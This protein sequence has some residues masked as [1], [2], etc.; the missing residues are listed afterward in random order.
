[1]HC[2]KPIVLST[3]NQFL[4]KNFQVIAVTISKF[5][6]V[7]V[8]LSYFDANFFCS[9]FDIDLELAIIKSKSS[10]LLSQLIKTF[11]LVTVI[12]FALAILWFLQINQRQSIKVKQTHWKVHHKLILYF[13]FSRSLI[14][15]TSNYNLYKTLIY[16][17]S[18]DKLV[19][20]ENL[21][22]KKKKKSF[23]A[24]NT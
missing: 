13:L 19:K 22:I 9:P 10:I 4:P 6:I 7:I 17:R 11:S 20:N 24:S 15:K 2:T 5:F 18:K 21:L 14:S 16:A 23:Q 8:I 12:C 3:F 1:M